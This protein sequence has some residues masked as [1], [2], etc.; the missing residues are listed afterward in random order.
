MPTEKPHGISRI[1]TW[2]AAFSLPRELLAWMGWEQDVHTATAQA[3]PVPCL[4]FTFSVLCSSSSPPFLLR[5]KLLEPVY[6]PLQPLGLCLGLIVE[7]NKFIGKLPSK[8]LTNA[9]CHEQYRVQNLT[10]QM[11]SNFVQNTVSILFRLF[12]PNALSPLHFRNQED[13]LPPNFTKPL[14]CPAKFLVCL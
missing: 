14:S 2:S 3:A 8:L 6:S 7:I 13:D 5:G 11:G 9:I 12:F 4:I 10:C 1:I